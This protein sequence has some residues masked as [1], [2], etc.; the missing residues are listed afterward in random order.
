MAE[1]LKVVAKQE[2]AENIEKKVEKAKDEATLIKNHKEQTDTAKVQA[3][4]ASEAAAA[5]RKAAAKAK[6]EAHQA[7]LAKLK[8]ESKK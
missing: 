3:I 4:Q 8:A 7:N 5:A 6:E 1:G 2:E